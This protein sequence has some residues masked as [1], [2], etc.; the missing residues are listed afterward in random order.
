MLMDDSHLGLIHFK[1]VSRRQ[2]T[3]PL[4]SSKMTT[5][6]FNKSK[7]GTKKYWDD[8]YKLEHK[9]FSENPEDTGECWFD[10]SGA[11]DKMCEFVFSDL[12]TYLSGIDVPRVCDLGTGNGHLLFQLHEEGLKGD[13]VG[14]DYSETSV[15]FATDIAIEKEVN[16]RFERS[17]IL[18]EDDQ[19]LISNEGTFDLV[20]D[21]GTMDAIALSDATYTDG[22][23]G[24]Q[25]Y[26]KSVIRLL[27]KGAVL[28]ITS[29]NFT[30]DEVRKHLTST[31]DLQ[32]SGKVDY[33]VFEFGGNKG[34]TICTVAFRKL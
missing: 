21:K 6:E 33:P 15:Q 22:L 25:T 11:E 32:F 24:F 18:C 4:F 16:V 30:E 5:P 1:T 2:R 9:N 20:L 8:F 31:G 34:S 10:E 29:C 12:A 27:K 3:S 26:P 19:F 7:L 17:D 14:V 23:T 28:L 13:L